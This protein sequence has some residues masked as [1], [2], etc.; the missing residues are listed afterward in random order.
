MSRAGAGPQPPGTSLRS[1][2]QSRQQCLTLLRH[3]AASLCH[4]PVSVDPALDLVWVL[5]GIVEGDADESGMQIRLGAQQADPPFL[6]A[7]EF[8]EAGDDLPDVGAGGECGAAVVRG[9]PEDD[10]WVVELINA[11][12][13]ELVK[14]RGSGHALAS[15]A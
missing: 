11:L 10:S 4:G 14:Q 13:D 3:A 15:G 5:G 6:G 1:G 2:R 9:A 8:L 12:N 7:V